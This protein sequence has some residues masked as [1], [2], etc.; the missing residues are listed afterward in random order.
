MSSNSNTTISM[1]T[2]EKDAFQDAFS[3]LI[4]NYFEPEQEE[5]RD[6]REVN[7]QAHVIIFP[8]LTTTS[9]ILE[10]AAA[11]LHSN[12]PRLRSWRSGAN[13]PRLDRVY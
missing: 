13:A 6:R 8:A 5:G 11:L 2:E 9:S 3:A 10:F 7:S 4:E 12:R 1:A